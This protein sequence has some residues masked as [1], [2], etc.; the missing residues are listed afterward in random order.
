MGRS[1]S[2]FILFILTL[3]LVFSPMITSIVFVQPYMQGRQYEYVW[4]PAIKPTIEFTRWAMELN[5]QRSD[6]SLISTNSTD[7]LGLVRTFNQ[8]AARLNM[9]PYVGVNWMSADLAD[10]DIIFL[11]NREY[12]VTI[13]NLVRPSYA[14]DVDIWR[15]N[16]IILT[17]SERILA[18][19][20]ATTDIVDAERLFNLSETPTIYYG[21]GGLWRE[22]DEIYLDIRGFQEMHLPEYRGPPSYDGE[23]D[24]TYDGFWR[25]WRFG[26]MFRWDFALGDYGDIKALVTRDMTT[27]IGRILIPGI[28]LDPDGYPVI[29]D[30]GNLYMLYWS[31]IS[32]RPPHGYLDYPEYDIGYMLRR[33]AIVL[34]N[35]KNGEIDG[36][37]MNDGGDYILNYYNRWYEGWDKP[38]PPWLVEQ[39]RYSETL[40]QLQ[41]DGYNF[42]FQDDFNKWQ[43]NQFYEPTLGEY[44][45]LI[46]DVRYIILPVERENKWSAV[47]LVEWYQSPSRNLAGMYVA[48]SGD[49]AGELY[50]VD[51]SDQTVIGPWT[52]LSTVNNDPDIKSQLTL[53][54]NII[55]GNILL[56]SIAGRLYYVIPWYAKQANLVLPAIMTIVDAYDQ[57]TS[58]YTIQNP[59]NSTEVGEA[60]KYAFMKLE[61]RAAE[62]T[63]QIS[64][65]ERKSNVL[66]LLQGIEVLKP[67]EKPRA[68]VEFL[69]GSGSYSSPDQW[70]AT[71]S[72]VKSFTSN[73]ASKTGRAYLWMEG[74][75]MK[76]GVLIN[77]EGIVELHYIA[78]S[79][80]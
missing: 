32:W 51:L 35:V 54:P 59:K 27:R 6:A 57:K 5:F 46:E 38:L 8:E 44:G 2:L 67:V 17:H 11:N 26:W 61:K 24:Y 72:L 66:S 65:E 76:L 53:R 30:K 48:P 4:Q 1:L 75:T 71:S 52:A 18:V 73:Y 7:V 80:G 31:W 62:E 50:F 74:N 55:H 9:K 16:H 25:M 56:Y 58:F 47:R 23:P 41:I 68:N 14:G 37:L 39:V 12:W 3:L 10:T 13:L 42:Y 60:A 19:D 69:L 43:T 63:P 22:V 70:E 21:E 34:V 45:E 78:I 40:L 36:Y 28:T 20:A 33:F 49:D 29:D 64:L 77:A 15:A 79:L